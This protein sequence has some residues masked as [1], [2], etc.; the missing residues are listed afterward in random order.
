M[1]A[2]A[3][4]LAL[5]LG[6]S[7]F[8]SMLFRSS[9]RVVSGS[10]KSVRVAQRE[11]GVLDA[12]Q[13]AEAVEKL[14]DATLT[15]SPAITCVSMSCFWHS[16]VGIDPQGVP[17][18]PLYLWS[19]G[20][21]APDA[22][23]LRNELDQKLVHSSTGAAVHP[24]FWPA[25]LRWLQRTDAALWK[26][27]VVWLSFGDYLQLRW[28]GRAQTSLSMASAT[29]LFNQEHLTWDADMLRTVGI[30]P[31]ML[32]PI[33]DLSMPA[34]EL[35]SGYASRWPALR[36]AAWLP[37]VGDGACS[38]LG[39]GAVGPDRWAITVGTSAAARV[40]LRHTPRPVPSGL[41]MYRLDGERGVIGGALNNGGNVYQWL[42]Q[43]FRLPRP[44]ELEELLLQRPRGVHGLTVD[45]SL[46]GDRSPN[47]PLHARGSISGLTGQTTSVDIAQA[48]LEATA[49][50]IADIARLLEVVVGTP[51][52]IVATGAAMV[53]S[54]A[55]RRM[56]EQSLGREVT[57]SPVRESSLRGAAALAG[58]WLKRHQN[59]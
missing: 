47:W 21:S 19:D 34:F 18:T 14:I 23:S 2:P 45:P 28:L 52:S 36:R 48:L 33:V 32:P 13:A 10:L 40:I 3:T 17:V 1:T 41:W 5:D 9:G 29:G 55:W 59:R 57:P 12:V 43:T 56:L 50:R 37:A 38:N 11:Q 20:R 7:S 44:R 16:M 31:S 51:R 46:F 25:K 54:V 30:E 26:A 58:E 6:T 8:R 39:V 49:D 27:A 4:I 35:R 24:T 15:A 53:R 42:R 22:Q